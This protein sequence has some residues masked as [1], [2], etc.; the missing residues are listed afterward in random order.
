MRLV[1]NLKHYGMN[2]Q[3]TENIGFKDKYRKKLKIVVDILYKACRIYREKCIEK[4]L[5]L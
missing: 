5:P 2:F 1:E 3:V 4:H